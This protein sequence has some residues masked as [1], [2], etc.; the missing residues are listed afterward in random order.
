MRVLRVVVVASIGAGALTFVV[1]HKIGLA[2]IAAG[3][4]LVGAGFMWILL[5]RGGN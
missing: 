5:R 1:S 2:M 3:S 4:V